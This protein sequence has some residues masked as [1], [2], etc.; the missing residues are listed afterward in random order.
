MI[1]FSRKVV[2]RFLRAL[3][4]KLTRVKKDSGKKKNTSPILFEN[5]YEALHHR[6]GNNPAS[7]LCPLH[8]CV[9]RT[10]LNFKS[11][12]WHPF[13]QT[14]EEYK[15]N[16]QLRYEDSSLKKYYD[17]WQP[18][19]ADQAV[20]GLELSSKKLQ[21]LPP[22]LIYL[23]PWSSR[24][25]NQMDLVVRCWH[26]QDELEHGEV[27]L[28]MDKDGFAL[29]GPVS[30]EK[31]NLEFRRLI[32]I[33]ESLKTNGYD[34]SHGDIGVLVLKRGADYRYLNSGDGYHRTAALA[35]LNFS[36]IP[37]RFFHPWIISIDDID[38]WPQVQNG[39]WNRKAAAE[40]FNHLFDFDSDAW[41]CKRGLL[42]KR[43]KNCNESS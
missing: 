30:K 25:I 27:F 8:K 15:K 38:Y 24:S 1:N 2:K 11:S 33:Y 6:R 14:L 29:F 41:A 31:G 36:K 20:T 42:L 19:S 26:K 13:V 7:L 23:S 12:G 9:H 16:K 40:Y 4:Y 32:T 18:L 28:N 21:S 34:R 5:M 35:A 17:N 10:G 39:I 3:G 37:A 43:V 22:Y